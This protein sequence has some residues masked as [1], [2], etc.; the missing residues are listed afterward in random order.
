MVRIDGI[1]ERVAD[2][3]A[4]ADELADLPGVNVVGLPGAVGPDVLEALGGRGEDGDDP[5][6]AAGEVVGEGEA[7]VA[8]ELVAHEG[9]LGRHLGEELLEVG[10]G[11]VEARAVYRDLERLGADV[12]G[13][14]GDELVGL[15]GVDA[16][17]GGEAGGLAL[18]LFFGHAVSLPVIGRSGP[19]GERRRAACTGEDGRAAPPRAKPGAAPITDYG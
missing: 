10:V 16:D 18:L 15:A 2:V 12:A 1:E 7:V 19:R 3:D 5:V 11:G 6:A 17:V 13:A 8:G 9:A 14:A 4:L